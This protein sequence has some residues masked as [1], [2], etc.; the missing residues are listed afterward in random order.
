[1]RVA[2][3][4]TPLTLSS[5]GLRRYTF[6]LSRALAEEFPGDEFLL[7][8]DRPFPM[9]PPRVNLCALPAPR[10]ALERR[11]W[12]WGLN[13]A[14]AR[15]RVDVFHGTNF[16]VPYWPAR[17]SVLTLHDLS[18]WKEDVRPPLA[19]RVRRR[20]PLLIRL[21]IATMLIVPTE[22][23]RREAR[24]RFRIHPD[25]IVA[26]PEAASAVFRPVKTSP[27]APYFLHVGADTPRKNVATIVEAWREVRK[28]HAVDLELA[29]GA[30]DDARL[31]ELYSGALAFLY[32]S[33]YEG[34]GLPLV[35]AMQCGAAVIASRD[36]A[37]MEV[38]G[39]AAVH[40]GARDT[41][42]WVEAM[43]AAIERPEWLAQQRAR[44]LERA[45]DFSWPRTARRTREVYDEARRRFA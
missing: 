14:L 26:V 23:V 27:A 30:V 6:E 2:L 12:S 39:G 20:T 1:M 41:R 21:R 10:S 22:A 19:G 7:A 13:R 31:A 29:S 43:T 3:D 35:E 42:A 18:P 17:P 32:P 9:P 4:A 44:S 34:F 15:E 33:L 8:C 24:A 25:R 45:R 16:E 36:P 11:W 28:H 40:A 38:C 5:G 37:V